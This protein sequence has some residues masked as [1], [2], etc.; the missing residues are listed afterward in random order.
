MSTSTPVS[1]TNQIV[2]L[3]SIQ[4]LTSLTVKFT[5]ENGTTINMLLDDEKANDIAE[6]LK[7][8][9]NIKGSEFT[10][11]A[12]WCTE[13][14]IGQAYLSYAI[15]LTEENALE[16]LRLMEYSFDATLGIN[17]DVIDTAIAELHPKEIEGLELNEYTLN[18]E[19]NLHFVIDD[20][21]LGSYDYYSFDPVREIDGAFEACETPEAELW[22]VYGH[23][24]NAGLECLAD[25]KSED[26]ALFLYDYLTKY[27]S[28]NVAQD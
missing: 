1:F 28:E 18:D 10:H 11:T 9:F 14:I 13:D 19:I 23:I 6:W 2:K 17:W 27:Y 7:D 20:I 26:S 8:N 5:S 16:V 15:D 21:K 3:G 12:G 24:P 22:S 25:C 4:N